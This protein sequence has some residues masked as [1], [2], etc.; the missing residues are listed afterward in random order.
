VWPV[1]SVSAGRQGTLGRSRGHLQHG[2]ALP[3]AGYDPVWNRDA[4]PGTARWW[5]DV[6]LL[7]GGGTA[8]ERLSGGV[9][10]AVVVRD[11]QS[12]VCPGSY[13]DHVEIAFRG[14]VRREC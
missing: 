7:L 10:D 3:D 8:A 1:Q 4:T 2:N 12:A 9:S 14:L 5:S 6:I 13:H 11:G